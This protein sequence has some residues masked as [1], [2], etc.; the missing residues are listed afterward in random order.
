MQQKYIEELHV[1][2]DRPQQKESRG[3]T[4]R[5][6]SFAPKLFTSPALCPL[7]L[8][9]DAW[10]ADSMLR[11]LPASL[12]LLFVR[13][14]LL[15]AAGSAGLS[16]DGPA[17]QARC[18]ALLAAAL[19]AALSASAASA[20]G[21]CTGSCGGRA[22]S[23]AVLEAAFS[24]A[25]AAAAAAC[26]GSDASAAPSPAVLEAAFSVAALTAAAACAGSD[27]SVVSAKS[28]FEK[29]CHACRICKVRVGNRVQLYTATALAEASAPYPCVVQAPQCPFATQNGLEHLAKEAPRRRRLADFGAL[30]LPQLMLCK[31]LPIAPVMRMG[32]GRCGPSS[33]SEQPSGPDVGYTLL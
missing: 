9:C 28:R 12:D 14:P 17:L 25:A 7:A 24:A 8:R 6:L 20:A 27:A 13:L 18:G 29:L 21:A 10:S 2:R 16:A 23:P 4:F 11:L 15:R 30:L 5:T 26:A 3:P 32:R 1:L 22:L 31:N 19:A 33:A